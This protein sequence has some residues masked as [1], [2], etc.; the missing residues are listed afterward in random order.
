MIFHSHYYIIVFFQT[1]FDTTIVICD[2]YHT[3]FVLYLN[4]EN[5][6]LSGIDISKITE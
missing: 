6:F 2:Q 3:I 5:K 1:T 4:L